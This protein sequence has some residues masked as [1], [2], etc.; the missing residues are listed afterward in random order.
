MEWYNLTPSVPFNSPTHTWIQYEL[1]CKEQENLIKYQETFQVI[2]FLSLSKPTD[3]SLYGLEV[4]WISF[5]PTGSVRSLLSW[6]RNDCQSD[7]RFEH[8]A[9][10]TR[11]YKIGHLGHRY[12]SSLV[13]YLC[14]WFLV[15]RTGNTQYK[16]SPKHIGP[17]LSKRDSVFQR[18]LVKVNLACLAN[19]DLAI[20]SRKLG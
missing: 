16:T 10:H 15:L 12:S 3:I 18:Q 13:S 19:G 20:T 2:S 11:N 7:T 9:Q 8:T 14:K 1:E 6:Y 5:K 4:P 17:G